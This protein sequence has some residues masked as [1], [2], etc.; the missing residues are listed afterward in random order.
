MHFQ[1]SALGKC[2]S[3]W[4]TFCFGGG[5]PGLSVSSHPVPRAPKE[6]KW[7]LSCKLTIGQSHK[8]K[9]QPARPGGRVLESEV[10]KYWPFQIVNFYSHALIFTFFVWFKVVTTDSVTAWWLSVGHKIGTHSSAYSNHNILLE[11]RLALSLTSSSSVS[12]GLIINV[13]P[14]PRLKEAQVLA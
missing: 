10:L 14:H 1:D 13:P 3:S 6:G 7:I 2:P 5:F 11:D 8:D 9:K 12:L 4:F